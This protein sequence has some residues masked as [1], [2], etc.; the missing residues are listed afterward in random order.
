M[1]VH[2]CAHPQSTYST[3]SVAGPD[4]IM[5]P[6]QLIHQR[7]RDIRAIDPNKKLI[8]FMGEW[9]DQDAFVLLP[10]IVTHLCQKNGI[11]VGVTLEK[12]HNSH[13]FLTR[14]LFQYNLKPKQIT[15]LVKNE[16]NFEMSLK[17]SIAHRRMFS[18]QNP[19][20]TYGMM[21]YITRTTI[22]KQCIDLSLTNGGRSKDEF[23]LTDAYTKD[24]VHSILG[25]HNERVL[26]YSPDGVKVRNLGM[27]GLIEQFQEYSNTDVIICP[28]GALHVHGNLS[29][30]ELQNTNYSHYDSLSH[31]FTSQSEWN[32][33][34]VSC[35][36]QDEQVP[37]EISGE[38]I[39]IKGLHGQRHFDDIQGA[40]GHILD[41][42]SC[43]NKAAKKTRRDYKKFVNYNIRKLAWKEG[44]FLSAFLP[45]F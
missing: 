5:A 26:A 27:F 37:K 29:T 36:L 10:N 20:R 34:S 11:K 21:D 38:S 15:E 24:L 43:L 41:L 42:K 1:N 13:S 22:P 23:D 40:A 35:L 2:V 9:H 18:Y 8:V 4:Q 17:G 7:I 16:H 33:L 30:K 32:V 31:I 39:F 44:R 28:V 19:G 12:P 25:S 3:V 14:N 45:A 6:A